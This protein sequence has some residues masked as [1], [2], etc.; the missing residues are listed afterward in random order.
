MRREM[1]LRIASQLPRRSQPGA[2]ITPGVSS[3][4]E[5]TVSTASTTASVKK[6]ISTLVVVPVRRSS[7]QPDVIPA[8]TSDAVSRPSAGHITSCSHRSSGRSPPMPRSSSIGVWQWVFTSPGSSTPGRARTGPGTGGASAI[9]PTHVIRPS[10]TS[11]APLRSTEH[12][13]SHGSTTG[14]VNA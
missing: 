13:G 9:G 6:Y 14:A 8:R 1:P 11:T 10:A 3:T 7:T 4:R 5:P 2:A 12:A